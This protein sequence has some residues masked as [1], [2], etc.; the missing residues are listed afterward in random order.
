MIQCNFSTGKNTAVSAVGTEKGS[1]SLMSVPEIDYE[2]I[3]FGA[4]N[5]E[6]EQG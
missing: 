1:L 5:K 6:K 3:T 4:I 2:I